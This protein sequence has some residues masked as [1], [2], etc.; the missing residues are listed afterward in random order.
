MV[1]M[2]LKRRDGWVLPVLTALAVGTF[3]VDLFTPR[4]TRAHLRFF[5]GVSGE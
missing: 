1:M 2:K 3:V 5:H 4:N